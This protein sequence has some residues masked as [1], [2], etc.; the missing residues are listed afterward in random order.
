MRLRASSAGNRI[1]GIDSVWGVSRGVVRGLSAAH[2]FQ[3]EIIVER[4]YNG[5]SGNKEFGLIQDVSCTG[6]V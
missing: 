5:A 2:V 6:E 1:H 4:I 3:D